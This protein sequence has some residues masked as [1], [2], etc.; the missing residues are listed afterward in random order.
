VVPHWHIP[1]DRV[2]YWDKFGRPEK[3]PEQG[4]QI[5]TWWVD[6]DKAAKLG[7]RGGKAAAKSP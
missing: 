5:D 3:V 1:Y 7:Q 6:P 4:V 2:A